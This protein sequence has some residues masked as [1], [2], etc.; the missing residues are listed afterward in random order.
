MSSMNERVLPLWLKRCLVFETITKMLEIPTDVSEMV[1]RHLTSREQKNSH[2]M[3]TELKDE[4]GKYERNE[5]IKWW[6]Q[7]LQTVTFEDPF[8]DPD[9]GRGPPFAPCV[10]PGQVTHPRLANSHS[11]GPRGSLLARSGEP[12]FCPRAF[13]ES[14]LPCGGTW[15]GGFKTFELLMENELGVELVN[16][17]RTIYNMNIGRF[18]SLTRCQLDFANL[19]M[20]LFPLAQ[21]GA[22]TLGEEEKK[23]LLAS[24]NVSEFYRHVNPPVRGSYACMSLDQR[25]EQFYQ[26]SEGI[27]V[28][29]EAEY[30]VYLIKSSLLKVLPL[31]E[32][33]K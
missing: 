19:Y 12:G 4:I 1:M 15:C 18:L 16:S 14:F 31:R 8:Y 11:R 6:E 33:R 32:L 3:I 29:H 7:H 26:H 13:C 20:V 25:R 9:N 2:M 27:M 30:Y 23:E 22:N 10:P 24:L 5:H 21:G 17:G 28:E